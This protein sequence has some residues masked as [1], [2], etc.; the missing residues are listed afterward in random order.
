MKGLGT[1]SHIKVGEKTYYIETS[2]LSAQREIL[3]KVT[4]EGKIILVRRME[5]HEEIGKGEIF[6]TLKNFHE[7]VVNEIKTWLNL[8]E[9]VKDEPLDVYINLAEKM[10]KM[11][12]LEN[13]KEILEDKLKINE[14]YAPL[15]FVLGKIYFN[16]KDYEKS[17]LF[18]ERAIQE[19][20]YP[21]YL[22][23][24]ARVYRFKKE[25]T[26]SVSYLKRA[27]D[28]NPSYAEAHFEMGFC[29]LELVL[30][31][32]TTVPFKTI[33]L[34]FKSAEIL[35]PR[36]KNE[37]FKEAL[38]LLE[39]GEIIEAKKLLDEFF[40]ILK[41]HDVN[42]ILEEFTILSKYADKQNLKLIIDDYILK[43]KEIREE[44]PE[45][46]DVRFNLAL[47]IFFKIKTLLEE[48][49]IEL[50]NA[51]SI[52]PDYENAKKV[53]ELLKNETEGYAL[54]LKTIGRLK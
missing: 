22:L 43:L 51:L 27:I 5:I 38:N 26:R 32:G 3:T 6:E 12:L 25:Y 16:L 13:A 34:S 30:N 15:N 23:W 50:E 33:I 37:K 45:Y 24:T 47:A 10:L 53:L 40:D 48:A 54:F 18:F 41:P 46:A 1:S 44:H 19:R 21:N 9:K 36:F 35:D 31:S 4:R 14:N 11:G 8:K 28:K 7:S 29:L 17:S 39:K 42:E 2:L 49:Q 20:E 52:N